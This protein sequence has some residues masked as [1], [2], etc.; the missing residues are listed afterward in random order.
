MLFCYSCALTSRTKQKFWY[1]PSSSRY[2]ILLLSWIQNYRTALFSP[3]REQSRNYCNRYVW[4]GYFF[5][6]K[7]SPSFFSAVLIV[8]L[9]QRVIVITAFNNILIGAMPEGNWCLLRWSS[10]PS[11][12]K[13]VFPPRTMSD[14]SI[15]TLPFCRVFLLLNCT[16]CARHPPCRQAVLFV[17]FHKRWAS[18]RYNIE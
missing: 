3:V 14:V 18:Q 6:S 5:H 9:R 11:F 16:S 12:V 15:E 1:N 17:F 2:C 13:L 10:T 8:I 7:Q 4:Q